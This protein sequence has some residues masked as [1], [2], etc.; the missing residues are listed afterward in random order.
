MIDKLTLAGTYNAKIFAGIMLPEDEY[1]H[2]VRVAVVARAPDVLDDPGEH[3]SNAVVAVAL[4]HDVVERYIDNRARDEARAAIKRGFGNAV[5]EAVDLLTRPGDMTYRDYINRIYNSGNKV[6][7]SVKLA[8]LQDHLDPVR[9]GNLPES[10]VKRYTDA[11]QTLS[12]VD[13]EGWI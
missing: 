9:V 7:A 6:A 10:M 1:L 13:L 5:S 8:D 3:V 2:S 4:L 11:Q 12:F